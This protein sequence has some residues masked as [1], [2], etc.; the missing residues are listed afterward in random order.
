MVYLILGAGVVLA[1]VGIVLF[2]LR[3]S[4]KKIGALFTA[5]GMALIGASFLLKKYLQN[6]R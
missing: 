5:L 1:L 6:K 2:V 3:T 4:P